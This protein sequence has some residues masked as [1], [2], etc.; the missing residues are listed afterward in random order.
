VEGPIR[1]N[2][3]RWSDESGGFGIVALFALSLVTYF[4]IRHG[5]MI[6]V[7]DVAVFTN[8]AS[9]VIETGTVTQGANYSNGFGYP[10]IVGVLSFLTGVSVPTLQLYVMPFML[11]FTLGATYLV[12]R[13]MLDRRTA[14]FGSLLL[15]MHPFLLFSTY[16]STHEKFTYALIFLALFALY[17]S[18]TSEDDSLKIRYI[19]LGYFI[20]S[21]LIFQNTFFASTFIVA[22]G[23]GLA[24]TALL[25]LY[26]GRSIELRRMSYTVIISFAMLMVTV[27][28]IYPPARRFLFS[29]G[30]SIA[31][32]LTLIFGNAPT[33]TGGQTYQS[34]M[35][36]WNSFSVYLLLISFYW[37]VFP[38]A[39]ITWLSRGYAILQLNDVDELPIGEI[40]VLLLFG[41]FSLQLLGGAIIDQLGIFVGTNAQL[42]V[43]PLVGFMSVI[44]TASTVVR[45]YR[46]TQDRRGNLEGSNS[47]NSISTYDPS[48]IFNRQT[49]SLAF[50]VILVVALVGFAG[51]ATLKA[52]ND[53]AV[54]TNWIFTT[55]EEQK[56]MDWVNT[57][58]RDD[59]VWVG[60][61]ERIRAGHSIRH[62]REPR[63]NSYDVANVDLAI[64][65]VMRSSTMRELASVAELPLPPVDDAH[66]IY[67]NGDTRFY[68]YNEY[69]TLD[70]FNDALLQ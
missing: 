55:P 37:I 40:F 33:A 7:V 18:F 8:A 60:Y 62:P 19:I 38:V 30:P 6:S 17:Q 49:F 28:F 20:I 22:A 3:E 29:L 36:E 51:A 69:R 56:A 52:S 11:L 4:Q 31:Q 59:Y 27:L 13:T 66:M 50:V 14:I 32:S 61:N 67:S 70:E 63:R 64:H 41:A 39:G 43:L 46:S 45:V 15:F 16:R 44:L 23:T 25:M 5:G 12:I 68:R 10:A 26:F 9:S 35:T 48:T 65:I 24:G 58:T 53:P 47:L 34:V 1:M 42:R 21:G 2:P 54:S 57:N